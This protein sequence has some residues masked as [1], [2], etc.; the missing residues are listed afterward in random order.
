MQGQLLIDCTPKVERQFQALIFFL[1]NLFLH[2]EYLSMFP[3]HLMVFLRKPVLDAKSTTF[4][5]SEDEDL[6]PDT[7]I[8][9]KRTELPQTLA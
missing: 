8:S 7:N 4:S 6:K 5:A 9:L 3:Y 1:Y 2:Y